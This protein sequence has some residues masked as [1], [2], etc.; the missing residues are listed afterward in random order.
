MESWKTHLIDGIMKDQSNRW[1]HERPIPSVRWVFHDSICQMGL[2]CF[3]LSDGSFMLPS[4]RWVFHDSI[5][6]MGLSW[7]HLSDGSFMIW[8]MES[9]GSFMIPSVRWVFH[10]SICQ[11]GSFMIPSG[12]WVFHDSIWQM[13]LSWFARWNHERPICQMESWK[14]HLPDGIMKDPSARWNHERPIC[15]ME[16]WKTHPICQD[17]SFMIPYVKMGRSWFHLSR[18]VF[19]DSICQDGSFMIPSVRWVFH[20]SICQMG[21]SWFHLLDG[22]F[23]IPSVRWVFH[24][25]TDGIMKDPSNRWNHERPI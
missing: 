25:L 8:Q 15:Q 12:R 6:Q 23:M 21:L 5:C 19:H 7:F 3:H 2:S 20:D 17:G 18:W 1:N 22:S 4:V 24:D 9:D 10:D 14:T 16:S 13:G 11:D